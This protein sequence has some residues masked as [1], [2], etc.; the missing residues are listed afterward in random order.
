MSRARGAAA[1]RVGPLGRWHAGPAIAATRRSL[2]LQLT[3]AL[4]FFP[5]SRKRLEGNVGWPP[6]SFAG[7]WRTNV[8]WPLVSFAVS[9]VTAHPLFFFCFFHTAIRGA[10]A[11]SSPMVLQMRD[12]KFETHHL[13]VS[14]DPL[15][16]SPIAL[17]YIVILKRKLLTVQTST[18]SKSKECISEENE[19]KHARAGH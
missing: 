2:V 13:R 6:T 4:L 7:A 12:A 8:G 9:G 17:S 14:N 16:A 15:G 19:D 11:C 5:S 10:S 1:Q 3:G 18:I